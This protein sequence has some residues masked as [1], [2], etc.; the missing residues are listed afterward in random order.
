MLINVNYIYIY[1]FTYNWDSRKYIKPAKDFLSHDRMKRRYGS[2][3]HALGMITHVDNVGLYSEMRLNEELKLKHH[4]RL[5][6]LLDGGRGDIFAFRSLLECARLIMAIQR[7]MK[8]RHGLK[9]TIFATPMRTK[10]LA[11]RKSIYGGKMNHPLTD[12]LVNIT[13]IQKGN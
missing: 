5:N 12:R 7:R 3:V 2:G 8:R 4:Y 10:C 13:K 1:F 6:K 9:D 11:D